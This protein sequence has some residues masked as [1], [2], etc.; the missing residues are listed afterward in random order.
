[1]HTSV[2]SLLLF[3]DDS[4]LLRQENGLNVGQNSAL[5][6]GHSGEK[7]VELLVVANGQ[8]EMARVDRLPLVVASGVS[9]Q[10]EHLGSEV[11]KYG[12]KINRTSTTDTMSVIALAKETV[13][14]TDWELE[15]S[16]CRTRLG[17]GAIGLG[18]ASF[19]TSRHSYEVAASF[20]LE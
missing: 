3:G 12:G 1:M 6:D 13:K 11:L 4:G 2:R 17:L 20:L 16:S 15:S 9:G 7:L 19:S 8:L 5:R 14:T 18:F 10:L